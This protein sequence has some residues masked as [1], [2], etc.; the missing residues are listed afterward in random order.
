MRPWIGIT[1]LAIFTVGASPSNPRGQADQIEHLQHL[2]VDHWHRAGSRGQGVKVAIL[3]TGFRGYRSLLGTMLP[4]NI[5]TRTFRLDGDLEARNSQHGLLCAEVVHVIAPAAE[6]IFVSWQPDS[7]QSFIDAVAYAKREGAKIISCS[8]IMPC[9][10]DSEGGG[11]NHEMLNRVIGTGESDGDVLAV[12]CA[13]NLAKRHWAGAFVE[14]GDGFHR[15]PNGA[16]INRTTAWGDEAVSIEMSWA[17]AGRYMLL[18]IDELGREVGRSIGKST[19]RNAVVRFAPQTNG[20]YGILVKRVEGNPGPF[21]IVTLGAW[22]AQSTSHGSIS[23][24]G[25]GPNWLTVGAWEQG[26]RADYSSCGP[27]SV[28]PKPDLVTRVP[29]PSAWRAQPFGGTSAA[30]PQVAG[31]AALYWSRH[32][33]ATAEQ[34]RS[35][36]RASARDVGAPG[37]DYESGFGLLQLPIVES[38]RQPVSG[39]VKNIE[40]PRRVGLQ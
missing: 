39:T 17:G 33:D 7:P 28:K 11:S 26:R 23:F 20:R 15:W 30:A 25:D 1:I 29:F 5:A 2:G 18:V 10:S 4:S 9:W 13:G 35:V 12:A 16:T 32:P 21:H 8:V 36:L 19:D 27:N 38:R 14:N 40:S 6:L 3:D 34:V 22:L 24:P 31:L 37:F